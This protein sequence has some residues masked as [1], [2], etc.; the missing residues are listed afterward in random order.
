[1]DTAVYA[2]ETGR[3]RTMAGRIAGNV[4]DEAFEGWR[5]FVEFHGITVSALIEAL[6]RIM[7]RDGAEMNH[8]FGPY[9]AVVVNEARQ[10]MAERFRR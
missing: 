10:V 5:T 7:A 1:M 8:D 3:L 6:G 2:L 9:T 4:S